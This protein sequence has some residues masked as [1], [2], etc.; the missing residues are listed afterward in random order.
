MLTF[1][2]RWTLSQPPRPLWTIRAVLAA[3]IL[4]V[5]LVGLDYSRNWSAVEKF[6]LASYART[7]MA[8]WPEDASRYPL[9]EVATAK[10]KV[11]LA[12]FDEVDVEKSAKGEPI[13]RL[14]EAGRQ[15]GLTG[16]V[17]DGRE[18]PVAQLASVP[19]ALGLSRPDGVGLPQ[20][21]RLQNDGGAEP[22][23]VGRRTAR[24]GKAARL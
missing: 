18:V 21:F 1:K 7:W 11:R 3:A 19:V 6:Y 12:L 17:L 8:M 13:Y 5:L 14:T 20:K 24:S 22:F 16:V 23:S 9:L 2:E 15:R 10:G 4:F